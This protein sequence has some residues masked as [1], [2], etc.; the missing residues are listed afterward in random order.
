MVRPTDQETIA[1]EKDSYYIQFLRG[2]SMPPH[3][4]PHREAPG[5]VRRQRTK[6]KCV[7]EPLLWFLKEGMAKQGKQAS[8]WLVRIISLSSGVSGLF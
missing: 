2:G 5:S 1:I 6:R 3:A 8:D 7:E 4:G